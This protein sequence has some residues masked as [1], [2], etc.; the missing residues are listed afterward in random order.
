MIRDITIGQYYTTNSTIHKLDPRLKT[1]AIVVYTICLFIINDVYSYGFSILC[2]AAVIAMSKVPL[3][4]IFR[5][6]KS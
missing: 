2:L 4:F 1:V 3:K 6:I 5:G